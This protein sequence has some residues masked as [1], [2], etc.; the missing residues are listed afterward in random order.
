MLAIANVEEFKE[1]AR[2]GGFQWKS[3]EYQ[4]LKKFKSASL[5]GLG[6]IDE[7]KEKLIQHHVDLVIFDRPLSGVQQRNLEE[8][9]KVQ[10]MDRHQLILDIFAQRA[11][12]Y[13]GKLQVE[14]AHYMD[15]LPRMVG[16]WKSSLSRQGG[17]IG[18]KG[19]SGA[20][21]PGEKAIEKDRRQVQ[22]RVKKIRQKLKAI[23]RARQARRSLRKKNQIPSLS[24]I[25]YTNSGKSTLLNALTGSHV[26]VQALPFMTLDPT[27]RKI[28][29]PGIKNVVITDT[30]GFIQNLSPHLVSAFKA[31]LEESESADILL[32]V[33]DLSSPLMKTHVQ[34]IDQLL[35]ELKWD[36]KPCLNVYNKVD[37]ASIDQVLQAQSYPKVLVS[38]Q[39]GK[40][41]DQLKTKISELITNLQTQEVELYF[42]KIDEQKIY[43]LGRTADIRKKEISSL[44]TLCIT[45]IAPTH[46][47]EW[48]KFLVNKDN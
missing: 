39:T 7:L 27:T 35:K 14:L 18:A 20:K 47:R 19:G 5:I 8:T 3:V 12:T 42:P 6:K 31:T 26:P 45:R 36:H 13:E 46:L 30:V 9:L 23:R 17:G 21:G 4:V 37:N 22:L 48:K 24:L 32:K 38:A 10:V 43:S 44:G 25:G 28:K 1:L 34:T 29:I 2:A 40:G 41:L 16:M 33:I 15:E 11:N